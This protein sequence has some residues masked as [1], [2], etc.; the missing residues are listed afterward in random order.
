MASICWAF[1]ALSHDH[2]QLLEGL[3]GTTLVL[4]RDPGEL[5]VSLKLQLSAST[6]DQRKQVFR[7]SQPQ[8]LAMIELVQGEGGMCLRAGIHTKGCPVAGNAQSPPPLD[9]TTKLLWLQAQ[10]LCLFLC[11]QSGAWN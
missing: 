7:E 8:A 5:L 11:V 6:R 1:A 2:P 10:T 4:L 9:P 3:A